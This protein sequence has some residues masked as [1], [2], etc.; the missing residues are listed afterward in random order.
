M[1]VT[2]LAERWGY[3]QLP[4]D[5]K[6][7]WFSLRP[8]RSPIPGRACRCRGETLEAALAAEPSTVIDLLDRIPASRDGR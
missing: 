8:H 6:A 5:G 7:V 2:K 3:R 4:N 1:L